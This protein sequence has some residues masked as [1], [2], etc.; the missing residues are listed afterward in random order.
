MGTSMHCVAY[1]NMEDDA[2]FQKMMKAKKFCDGIEVSYPREVEEYFQGHAQ[3]SEQVIIEEM[4]EIELTDDARREYNDDY[5][6]GFEIIVK[7][8]PKEVGYIRF[9]MSY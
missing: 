7:N 8:I 2:T 1:R 3:E 4:T 5:R 9:F 6:E